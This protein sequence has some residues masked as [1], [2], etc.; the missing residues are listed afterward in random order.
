MKVD[1]MYSIHYIPHPFDKEMNKAGQYVYALCR[2]VR[3]P[4][5]VGAVR[6][7]QV[8]WEPVAVFERSSPASCS[9]S[10]AWNRGSP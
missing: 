3:L 2:E 8:S 10:S 7:K 1:L 9:I 6:G 5:E 4:V